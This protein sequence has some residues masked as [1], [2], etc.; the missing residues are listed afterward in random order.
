MTRLEVRCFQ[1]NNEVEQRRFARRASTGSEVFPPLICVD[2]TRFLYSY[3]DDLLKKLSTL[4]AQECKKP[5][6]TVVAQKSSLL[7]RPNKVFQNLW[8]Y[9]AIFARVSYVH[10][11][12]YNYFIVVK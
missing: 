2:A 8:I 7:T 3:R 11:N 6:L 4:D 1:C 12:Y 5:T 9:S 10:N